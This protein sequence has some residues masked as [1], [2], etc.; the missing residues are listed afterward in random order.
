MKSRKPVGILAIVLGVIS[1]FLGIVVLSIGIG[2][3]VPALNKIS[4]PI[5]C[6]GD[7]VEIERMASNPRPG[8]TFV[9]IAISCVDEQTGTREIKTFPMIFAS[10]FIYSLV[11]FIISM[12]WFITHPDSWEV[13]A[14]EPTDDKKQNTKK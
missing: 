13:Y 3:V 9:S 6:T 7:R 5:V 4:A 10:G 12:I 1:L 14:S 11:I 2:S 8:E